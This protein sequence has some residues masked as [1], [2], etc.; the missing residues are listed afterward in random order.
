MQLVREFFGA[1]LLGIAPWYQRA[2]IG[3]GVG[4]NGKSTLS[5]VMLQCMPPGTTSAIPP[6]DWGQEY[7]RAMLMGKN[8]N[9]VGELPERE[10]LASEALKSIVAGHTSSAV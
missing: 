3:V 5:D 1:C 7:R 4:A 2:L 6:Q 9:S 8:L 10:I